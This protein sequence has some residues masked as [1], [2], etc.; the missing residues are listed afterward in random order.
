MLLSSRWETWDALQNTLLL[1]WDSKRPFNNISKRW[2][3]EIEHLVLSLRRSW[4]MLKFWY[5]VCC[6]FVRCKI[7]YSI[8]IT[9]VDEIIF[10]YKTKL[11]M[12]IIIQVY[13]YQNYWRRVSSGGHFLR[14]SWTM[15][16]FWYMVCGSFVRCKIP[17]SI[18]I[19][20]VDE[21]I[22]SYKTKLA[23]QI[24]IHVCKYQKS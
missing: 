5:M 24:I 6:S 21:I 19:T 20:W 23:M 7:P 15:L 17:Y 12:Q 11:I 18:C 14:R 16:K 1:L 2:M 9:Q 13:K 22:F 3:Q 10:P 4:T 8:C